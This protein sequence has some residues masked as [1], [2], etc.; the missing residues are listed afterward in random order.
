L[1]LSGQTALI[2]GGGG[3]IGSAVARELAG[4]GARVALLG[5]TPGKLDAARLSLGPQAA[6]AR[7]AVC[8]VNDREAVRAAVAGVR[9]AFGRMDILVCAAGVNVAQR[10]LRTLDPADWDR[11]VSTNLTGSFNVVHAV[12]PSMREHGRGLIVFLSS[13]SGLRASAL[14]GAAYSASKAA[15]AFL[16]TCI[17]REERGRGIRSTVI[18]AGEVDTPFLDSRGS[19]PGGGIGE[20]RRQMLLKPE[21]V[22]TAIGFLAAL[23]DRAAVPELVLKPSVDDFA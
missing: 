13:I 17:G 22:A 11:V 14:A 10:S 23:P 15:E 8:D 3:A 2:A 21:D 7:T 9:E 6:D 19:R 16:A 20:S 18:Y 1:S 4:S 5:R 12:L